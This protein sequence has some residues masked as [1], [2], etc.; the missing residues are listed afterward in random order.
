MKSILLFLLVLGFIPIEAGT[1]LVGFSDVPPHITMKQG[2]VFG[3]AKDYI[4]MVAKKAGHNLIWVKVNSKKAVEML[5]DGQLDFYYAFAHSSKRDLNLQFVNTPLAETMYCFLVHKN[6]PITYEEI[7]NTS[8]KILRPLG[9]VIIDAL[10]KKRNDFIEIGGV[11]HRPRLIQ[12][13]LSKRVRVAYLPACEITNDIVG[14]EN[15][16]MI[17]IKNS[18]TKFYFA[19][20]KK[21]KP[22][23][24][25]KFD[26]ILAELTEQKNSYLEY[27]SRTLKN[28]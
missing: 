3:P 8:I 14:N 15:I 20:S 22:E 28:K 26:E 27:Y 17:N 18:K 19:F 12:L 24:V 1:L 13:I 6:D 9:F 21:V 5:L 25:K 10:S 11:E 7:M 23:V 16:R 4:D 2:K